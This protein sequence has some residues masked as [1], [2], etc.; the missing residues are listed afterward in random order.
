MDH[1]LRTPRRKNAV[2]RARAA[3]ASHVGRGG[4]RPI[5][6]Q[7]LGRPDDPDD[8]ERCAR[9]SDRRREIAGNNLDIVVAEEQQ[10]TSRLLHR[11]VVAFGERTRI[12]DTDDFVRMTR[13]KRW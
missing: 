9:A 10:F 11:A 7:D 3:P 4:R 1:R 2:R 13:K 12:V 8:V 6:A 5:A